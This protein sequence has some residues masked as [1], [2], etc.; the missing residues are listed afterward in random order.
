MLRFTPPYLEVDHFTLFRDEVHGDLFYYLNHNPHINII[1]E[2]PSVIILHHY[3]ARVIRKTALKLQINFQALPDEMMNLRMHVRVKFKT[4]VVYLVPV[5]LRHCKVMIDLYS[6]DSA[7]PVWT[8]KPL[9]QSLENKFVFHLETLVDEKYLEEFAAAVREGGKRIRFRYTVDFRG[10]PPEYPVSVLLNWRDIHRYFED[11]FVKEYTL[12]KIYPV[13]NN[14]LSKAP[15]EW[16]IANLG[17]KLKE[18]AQNDLLNEFRIAAVKKLFVSQGLSEVKSDKKFLPSSFHEAFSP[19]AV[20]LLKNLSKLDTLE[21]SFVL[22]WHRERLFSFELQNT[23]KDVVRNVDR[24][25]RYQEESHDNGH[26]NQINLTV[27]VMRSAFKCSNLRK[28]EVEGLLIKKGTSEVIRR[29]YCFFETGHEMIEMFDYTIEESL[30]DIQIMHKV[31]YT[32]Q[33]YDLFSLEKVESSWIS[34]IVPLIF[35]DPADHFNAF[36]ARIILDKMKRLSLYDAIHLN[37]TFFNEHSRKTL[38][39]TRGELLDITINEQ[40]KVLY[41]PEKNVKLEVRID[42]F[43]QNMLA[44]QN[45]YN[46]IGYPNFIVDNQHENCWL[47]ALSCASDWKKAVNIIVETTVFEKVTNFIFRKWHIFSKDHY[48]GTTGFSLSKNV[49]PYE[50]YYKVTVIYDDGTFV[51]KSGIYHRGPELVIS[52]Q[53]SNERTINIYL[54]EEYDFSIRNVEYIEV[55]I[56]YADVVNQ[57]KY[58]SEVGIFTPANRVVKFTHPMKNAFLRDYQFRYNIKFRGKDTLLHSKWLPAEHEKLVLPVR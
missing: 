51:I 1:G 56:R 2:K 11:T 8:S 54:P 22:N 26:K 38:W 28:I 39:E 23:L 37:V 18:L 19:D 29:F 33:L 6:H 53:I 21:E 35:I 9:Q 5:N 20:L 13:L 4:R 40:Y 52:D 57:V 42:Y 43:Q 15:L 17:Q 46:H 41:T 24:I 25:D 7:E 32:L 48:I 3:K 27:S 10:L 49:R 58:Y 36:Y 30:A 31:I 45:L 55:I 44:A 16:K 50:F 14:W 47:V 34:N 12:E